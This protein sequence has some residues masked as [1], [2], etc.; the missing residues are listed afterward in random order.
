MQ[1]IAATTKSVSIAAPVAEIERIVILDSLRGF[2]ILGILLMNI[3]SFGSPLY[4]DLSVMNETG[5]N[6]LSWYMMSWFFEGTQQALSQICL[7]SACLSKTAGRG[8]MMSG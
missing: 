2:A 7:V 1:S 8:G 4:S 3:G 5:V 6:Y